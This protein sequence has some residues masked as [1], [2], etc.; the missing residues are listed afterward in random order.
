[1][2]A[3]TCDMHALS[4]MRMRA[5]CLAD[6]DCICLFAAAFVCS[7]S[8]HVTHGPP[9]PHDARRRVSA[10]SAPH[11]TALST[12]T[13]TISQSVSVY[14]GLWWLGTHAY[15]CTCDMHALS[16]MRMR[17]L[18]LAG[19]DCICLF[20]CCFCLLF[21]FVPHVTHGLPFH[22]MRVVVSRPHRRHTSR[23]SRHEHTR[24]RS[25]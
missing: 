5:L 20:V 6:S 2:H 10:T 7:Y 9:F 19:S 18:C 17:A 24:S 23:L 1:M 3:C 25:L 21:I 15:A 16:R 8:C 14:C 11:I 22:M 12:R 4:C 13:H